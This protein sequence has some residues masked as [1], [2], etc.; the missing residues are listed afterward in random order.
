MLVGVDT[1]TRIVGVDEDHGGGVLVG[2]GLR[3]ST[4]ISHPFSGMRLK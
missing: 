2:D 4:S 1:P 3:E